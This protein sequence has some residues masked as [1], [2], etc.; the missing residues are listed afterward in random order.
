MN[1]W[2]E[3]EEFFNMMDPEW[4]ADFGFLVDILIY[5]NGLNLQLQGK[6]Q[7]VYILFNH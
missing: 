6:D 1:S 2:E 4:M 3:R 7:L 5:L